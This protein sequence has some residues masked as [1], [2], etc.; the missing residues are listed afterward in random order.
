MEKVKLLVGHLLINEPEPT[1]MEY[2]HTLNRLEI[3]E[4]FGVEKNPEIWLNFG[5]KK[6]IL[7]L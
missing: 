7:W 5:F 2:V 6:D 4:D 3:L 1:P